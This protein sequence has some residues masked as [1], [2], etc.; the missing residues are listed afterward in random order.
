MEA[1]RGLSPEEAARAIHSSMEKASRRTVRMLLA[2]MLH[3]S[4]QE[5]EAPQIYLKRL[6]QSLVLELLTTEFAGGTLA[7]VAVRPML[8]QLADEIVAAGG[9]SGPH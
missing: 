9:Y 8:N 6:S 1:A 2:S 3:Y 5:G 7:P 4:P